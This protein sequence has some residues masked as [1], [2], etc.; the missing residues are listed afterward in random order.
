MKELTYY[1]QIKQFYDLTEPEINSNLDN[2]YET[3]GEYAFVSLKYHP[4]E[5]NHYKLFYSRHYPNYVI[6][7][8]FISDTHLR[9]FK[10]AHYA[11]YINM[12]QA[13]PNIISKD[14]HI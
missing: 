11:L 7:L 10:I 3:L 4:H 9:K 8:R 12:T 14:E 13:F 1:Y 2:I 6:Q 5:T